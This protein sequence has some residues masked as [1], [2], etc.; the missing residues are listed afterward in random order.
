MEEKKIGVVTHYYGHI[1]VGIIKI[2]AEGLKIGDTLH[3]K[4]HTSDFQQ[5]IE[6]MQVEH[7]DVQEANV[8][9]QVGVR[10]S[11]HVREHDEVFKIIT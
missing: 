11:D 8:G 9:E 3:F 5:T 4:G 1:G 2:E 6:S 7:K 10:V